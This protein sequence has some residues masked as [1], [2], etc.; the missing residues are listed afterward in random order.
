MKKCPYCAEKIQNE[1][2]VCRYCGRDLPKTS[3]P[4]EKKTSKATQKPR[5]VS[6]PPKSSVWVQ[7][8]KVAAVFTAIAVI[9]SIIQYHNEPNELIENLIIGPVA[10]FI[11]WWLLVTGIIALWRKAGEASW[12]RTFLIIGIIILVGAVVSVVVLSSVGKGNPFYLFAPTPT[13]TPTSTP[14]PSAT[15]KPT[16]IPIVLYSDDFS[17]NQSGWMQSN[18]ENGKFQYLDGHYVIDLPASNNF[19][20]VCPNLNYTDAVLSVD[21]IYTSGD[22][23][24]GGP[25]VIWR[26]IDSNNFYAFSFNG[27]NSLGVFKQFND[28]WFPFGNIIIPSKVHINGEKQTNKIA[29]SFKGGISAIYLNGRFVTSIK[30]STFTTGGI[31]LGAESSETSPVEVSFDN[32]VVYS[33]NNW[34]PPSP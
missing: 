10:N 11:G 2:I 6:P 21:A 32:L 24:L 19:V 3:E 14:I 17:N 29:I 16:Q 7:G 12:G 8:A 5:I 4:P 33:I 26:E 28:Q 27:A 30:N 20:T 23:K 9:A 15:P 18:D 31:C 1:A 34:T 22:V 25:L 13:S